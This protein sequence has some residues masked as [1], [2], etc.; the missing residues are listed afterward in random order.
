MPFGRFGFTAVDV[1][2]TA[3]FTKFVAVIGVGVMIENRSCYP[4]K[5]PGDVPTIPGG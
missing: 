3:P 2:N 1:V 4:K 5:I